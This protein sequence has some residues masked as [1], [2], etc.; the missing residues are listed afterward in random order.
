M[1]KDDRKIY[2]KGSSETCSDPYMAAKDLERTACLK[3]VYYV[4]DNGQVFHDKLLPDPIHPFPLEKHFSP[5]YY[6]DLYLKV[7][8]FFKL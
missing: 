6:I 8:S 4:L 2:L 5:Q 7:K 3:P 1:I